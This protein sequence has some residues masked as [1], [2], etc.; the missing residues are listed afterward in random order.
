MPRTP[1]NGI[2]FFNNGASVK[3]PTM[4][5]TPPP[6]LWGQVIEED[7][8]DMNQPFYDGKKAAL[9]ELKK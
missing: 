9:L 7:L 6:P 5:K 8:Y 2:I 4:T 1:D 3:N